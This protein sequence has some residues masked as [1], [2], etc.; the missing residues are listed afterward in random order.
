MALRELTIA[1][2]QEWQSSFEP[3]EVAMNAA[4]EIKEKVLDADIIEGA[5]AIVADIDATELALLMDRR[6]SRRIV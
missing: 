1:K 6:K 5:Q 2:L 3:D 4:S